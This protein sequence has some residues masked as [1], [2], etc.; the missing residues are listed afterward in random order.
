MFTG[1]KPIELADA[2]PAKTGNP[3]L[4]VLLLGVSS[5]VVYFVITF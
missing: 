4:A 1:R 3:W 2:R 5:M